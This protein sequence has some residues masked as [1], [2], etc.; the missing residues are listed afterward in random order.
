MFSGE[1]YEFFKNTFIYR[2]L[3]LA[4]SED[5][6]IDP[7]NAVSEAFINTIMKKILQTNPQN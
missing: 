6:I 3:P 7:V 2:I 1:F 4:A 5:I